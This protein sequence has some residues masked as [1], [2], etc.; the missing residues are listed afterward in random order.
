MKFGKKTLGPFF[1]LC[2]F[3]MLI[4]SLS[5]EVIERIIRLAPSLASFTL[6]IQEPIRLFDFYVISLYFR[7]NPG[8]IIGLVCGV[9][10]FLIV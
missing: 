4:G 6:T 10:L 2:L 8:T 5:W 3:G 7:A 1:A 9:I